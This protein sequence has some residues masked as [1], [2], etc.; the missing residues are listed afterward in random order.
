MFTNLEALAFA[1]YFL[2]ML[3]IGI[4]FFFKA[5]NAAGEQEYFL[6]GRKMAPG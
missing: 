3:G 6:G 1:I 5:K 4:Y 2:C